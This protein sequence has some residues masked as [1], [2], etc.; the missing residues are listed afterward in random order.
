MD[1]KKIKENEMWE[2]MDF[3]QFI[4]DYGH[5]FYDD[6]KILDI[7]FQKIMDGITEIKK[8]VDDNYSR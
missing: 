3:H 8:I 1:I 7:P 4:E 2:I 6:P 5:I